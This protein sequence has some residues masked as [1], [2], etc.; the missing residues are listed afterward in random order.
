MSTP[1]ARP[2]ADTGPHLLIAVLCEKVLQESDGVLS[3][4]RVIDRLTQG[5]AGPEA[6]EQMPPFILDRLTM[7]V[8]IRAD[9]ARGRHGIKIRPEAP[10][11]L[12]MQSV[13]Q[14][15]TIQSGATGINLIL[16]LVLPITEEGVYWFDVFLTGPAPQAD[17]LLTRVP[18]EIVYAPQRVGAGP[19]H[20][21]S[22]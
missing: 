19:E 3:V 10:S 5:A 20:P 8:A 11:G 1:E 18:L 13:E 9:Q 6:P 7:L 4:I 12:Q 17:R 15:V 22:E 2:P 14:G 16:P 21:S